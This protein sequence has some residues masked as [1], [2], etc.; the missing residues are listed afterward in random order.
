M[1]LWLRSSCMVHSASTNM[2]AVQAHQIHSAHLAFPSALN[3]ASNPK[4]MRHTACCKGAGSLQWSEP[5]RMS[6]HAA[7]QRSDRAFKR[8][9]GPCPGL[10]QNDM[11][12][13]LRFHCMHASCVSIAAMH[14]PQQ[15]PACLQASVQEPLVLVILNSKRA[16]AKATV[17]LVHAQPQPQQPTEPLCPRPKLAMHFL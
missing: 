14:W 11:G 16:K 6:W 13:L 1:W 8:L 17:P 9:R 7:W 2:W 5:I 3:P 4:P 15:G 10:Q 12:M